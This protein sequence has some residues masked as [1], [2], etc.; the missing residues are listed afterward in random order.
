MAAE[1]ADAGAG[2]GASGASLPFHKHTGEDI[3]PITPSMVLDCKHGDLNRL[4]RRFL[5]WFVERKAGSIDLKQ[6]PIRRL[7]S[8]MNIRPPWERTS[9][10]ATAAQ[11]AGLSGERRVQD[12]LDRKEVARLLMEPEQNVVSRVEQR[13]ADAVVV[14]GEVCHGGY[15]LTGRP[16]STV[17]L[18]SGECVPFEIKTFSGATV[19]S[20]ADHELQL[21]MYM[22]AMGARRG[23]LILYNL[24]TGHRTVRTLFNT[25]ATVEVRSHVTALMERTVRIL[26]MW[27]N[28]VDAR[29]AQA[30]LCLKAKGHGHGRKH[31]GHGHK[32]HAHTPSHTG[33]GAGAGAGAGTGADG[34]GAGVATPP[35][36]SHAAAPEPAE[37]LALPAETKEGLLPASSSAAGLTASEAESGNQE[38]SAST[39]EDEAG[40]ESRSEPEAHESDASIG[41]ASPLSESGSGD[42]ST[43]GDELSDLVDGHLS[44][45]SA[46]TITQTV[47]IRPRK[48]RKRRRRTAEAEIIAR[49]RGW[50][51]RLRDRSRSARSARASERAALG[52]F[53]PPRAK[54]ARP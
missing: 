17:S 42:G 35:A 3:V 49:G 33:T 46:V 14:D 25:A 11:I 10:G 19:P 7:M 41:S 52:G 5:P 37:P 15:V 1:A 50:G 6:Q 29:V 24:N 43:Q 30:T 2:A 34:A 39:V 53:G 40:L 47:A 32:H 9:H 27:V 44:R 51:M 18:A 26:R 48:P 45:G 8:S 22:M 20:N 21:R 28:N 36:V 54:R 38:S 13:A 12:S 16:D 31:A 4:F 23:L